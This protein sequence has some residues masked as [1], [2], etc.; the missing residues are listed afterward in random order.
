MTALNIYA[1]MF[2]FCD[3]CDGSISL[4]AIF[5][6]D[7]YADGNEQLRQFYFGIFVIMIVVG[8]AY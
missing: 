3:V 7:R 1:L 8:S 2:L 4:R 5:A 6:M